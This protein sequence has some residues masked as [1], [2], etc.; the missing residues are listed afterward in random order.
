MNRFT[1]RLRDA[2]EGRLVTA[3]KSVLLLEAANEI[4]RLGD[5]TVS[6]KLSSTHRMNNTLL[7]DND[8]LRR[9]NAQLETLLAKYEK[10]MLAVVSKV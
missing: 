9:R 1:K 5:S 2:A 8:R 4:D 6:R 3:N 7:D 10:K